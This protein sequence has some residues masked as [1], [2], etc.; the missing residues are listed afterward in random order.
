MRLVSTYKLAEVSF[1][2]RKAHK[3]IKCKDNPLVVTTVKCNKKALLFVLLLKDILEW[4][5]Q[6]MAID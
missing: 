3:P 6:R 2:K 5:F 1:T 4:M